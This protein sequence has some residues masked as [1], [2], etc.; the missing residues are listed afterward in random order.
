MNTEHIKIDID[1]SSTFWDQPPR[2]KIYLDSTVIYQGL[3]EHAQRITH[4]FDLMEGAH[5]LKVLLMGKD[6]RTQTIVQDGEIIKD[7]LLN[8]DAVYFDDINLGYACQALSEYVTDNG[9]K[10]DNMVN[11]GINGTWTLRFS[12]PIYTWLLENI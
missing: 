11:L 9:V 1:I 8:I 12:T 4:E 7:Q 6:G 3:V 10:W 2:T 5:E